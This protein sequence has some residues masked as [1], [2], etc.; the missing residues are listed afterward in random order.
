ML[1]LL[2]ANAVIEWLRG[3]PHVVRFFEE[4]TPPEDV[5]ALNAICVAEVYSGLRPDRR[6]PAD[7]LVAS[8]P[9]WEIDEETAK[10]AGDYRYK[11]AR[12]ARPLTVSDTLMAAHAVTKEAIL[13]TGNTR[14][15]PMPELRLPSLL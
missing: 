10:L 13:I 12:K 14:D 6:L 3:P 5:V 15:F 1:Y 9:Y 8:L 4:L 2:D 11:Y 7:R